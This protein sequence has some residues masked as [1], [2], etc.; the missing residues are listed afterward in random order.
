MH[1]IGGGAE[2]GRGSTVLPQKPGT[3]RYGHPAPDI[4]AYRFAGQQLETIPVILLTPTDLLAKI[5]WRDVEILQIDAEGHDWDLL[6]LF[7]KAGI[8]A[9]I[10]NI[11]VFN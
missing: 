5:G 10:I 1:S 3:Y 9:D 7:F 11:E 4:M 6:Q 2:L 8:V